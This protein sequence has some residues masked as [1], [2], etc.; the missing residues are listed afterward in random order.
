MSVAALIVAAFGEI[1][2]GAVNR[3]TGRHPD[4][5]PTLKEIAE[6]AVRK[7]VDVDKLKAEL[8]AVLRQELEALGLVL[9][10]RDLV[11]QAQQVPHAFDPPA[12]RTIPQLGIDVELVKD[13]E[14]L[15]AERKDWDDVETPVPD[16]SSE[17]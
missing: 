14:Q 1:A 15:E 8:E 5:E 3:L 13:V 16:G 4:D 6:K 2:E 9:A 17:K 10:T 7:V 12:H 11:D